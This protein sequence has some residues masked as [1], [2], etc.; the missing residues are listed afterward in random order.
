MA[1]YRVSS[2][3][4]R[5]LDLR[6]QGPGTLRVGQGDWVT[7]KF[8]ATP[9]AV[10]LAIGMLKSQSVQGEGRFTWSPPR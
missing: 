9:S 3:K 2:S 8:V 6:G 7:D 4:L 5:C 1:T 10:S